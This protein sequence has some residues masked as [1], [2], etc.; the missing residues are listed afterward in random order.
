MLWR[1]RRTVGGREKN[2]PEDAPEGVSGGA[3]GGA[4]I[5]VER[6]AP[7][8][9]TI[10]RVAG[11]LEKRGATI[12]ELFKEV[13]SEA[14]HAVLPIHLAQDGR[15]FFVEVVTAPWD[16]RTVEE[17]TGKVV[18]LRGSDRSGAG[19]EVLSA[20]PVPDSVAFLFDRSPAA[21]LQ[22]D[23]LRVNVARP[24]VA[25]DIFRDVGSRH[26][27]V[28]LRYELDYLPLIEDLL[29][30]ALEADEAGARPP[31]LNTLVDGLGCFV[32]ETIRR[33]TA[34]RS[35]WSPAEGWSA[36]PVVEAGGFTLDPVG[37]AGAFL[38]G[39][40]DDSVAFYAEYVLGELGRDAD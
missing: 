18:V 40:A 34:A 15:D 35:F 21:L 1:G 28:D 10:L 29:L 8:P 20:Y 39:G 23:L 19:L 2:T 4:P 27:G 31:V 3:L 6:D 32:G 33:S 38:R 26:W 22:L 37:K 36:G 24:E 12:L 30:A 11:E 5:R 13:K 14:G 25:A 7:R 16:R 9:A 17:V